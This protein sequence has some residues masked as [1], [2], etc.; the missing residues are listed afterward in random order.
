LTGAPNRVRERLFLKHN[1]I[2]V[3]E[4][5]GLGKISNSFSEIY[6]K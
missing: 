1:D 6:A 2:Y 4:I 3:C 5:E